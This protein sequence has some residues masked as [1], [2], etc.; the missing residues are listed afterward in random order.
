VTHLVLLNDAKVLAN[1][2]LYEVYPIEGIDAEAL[3]AVLNSTVFACERYAAVKALGREAAIDVEVF[4]ANSIKTPDLRL[5]NDRDIELLRNAMRE[6]SKREVGPILE[7]SLLQMTHSV[8]TAYISRYPVSS[9]VWP[10]ELRDSV[11]QEIDRLVLKSVGVT[12]KDVS[13]TREKLYN[14]LTEHTRGCY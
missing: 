13:H 8:A 11:R 2:R 7:E 5:L 3:C 10:D 9:Q 12:D 1:Q 14:E 4:S 6:L